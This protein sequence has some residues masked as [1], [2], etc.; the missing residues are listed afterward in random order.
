MTKS[1]RIPAG[2]F[3]A[4]CLKLMDEVQQ[5]G[6]EIVVTKRGKPVVRLVPAGG[7]VDTLFG[8]MKGSA[9]SHGDII[10]PFHEEW[11]SEEG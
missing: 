9:T 3:K 4:Q 7:K 6:E 8:I 10:G 2:I 11:Q 1:R 5:T